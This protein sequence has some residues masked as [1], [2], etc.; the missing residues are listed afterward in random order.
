[1]RLIDEGS[2]MALEGSR[3]AD[4]LIVWAWR[5]GNLVVP[6]P[7][8]VISWSVDDDA[9]DSV[10]V[11][12]KLSLTVADLDGSLGAWRF[13]DALSVA[14][15]TLRVIYRVGGSGAVNFGWFRV[16]SNEP[17]SATDSRVVREYGYVE[18][19]ALTEPHLRRTYTNTGTVKLEAVDLTFDVDRDKFEAPE[20]A[21]G[22]TVLGEFQRLTREHFP[23]VV[24]AGVS[25]ATVG[26]FAVWDRER[27]E[28]CQDLLARINARYRMG[29]DGECHVYPRRSDP[30]WRVEPTAGLVSVGRTQSSDGLYNRWVVEGKDSEGGAPVRAAVS[31]DNGPLAYGGPH[32]KAPF[33][34]SSEMIE[35]PGQALAYAIQLRD[36]FMSS[37]AVELA[38]ETIPRPELQAGDWIEVG[39]PVDGRVA[40][41]PGQITGIR[42][43]GSTVPSGTSLTVACSYADVSAA[44]GRTEW[45]DHLTDQLP[46]LTWDRMPSSWGR[47]PPATWNDLP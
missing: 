23:T 45:A 1:V 8:Q 40:Y 24:D 11:G 4:E 44:L 20:S 3:P 41:F 47:I 21:S 15:T 39:C 34:Y 43:G 13:E 2:L 38:V 12:Q 42:R 31:I 9:G 22:A 10:K 27:L 28:A 36:E 25:D 32:G 17:T 37:L 30:V 29:G 16:T 33:F 46:P 7:L 5:D 18:P 19:D 26:K 14:G 35:T 6:E